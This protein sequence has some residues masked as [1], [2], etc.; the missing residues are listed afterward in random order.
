MQTD[1]SDDMLP[2]A[3]AAGAAILLIGGGLFA[4][5]RR[6]DDEEVHVADTVIAAP[7]EPVPVAPLPVQA[8][9]P[10]APTSHPV[11]TPAMPPMADRPVA[12]TS[13]PT[14]A[15]PAGFDL[16]RFGRHTQ[17]AYAGP[18]AD[19]PFLSLKR[20]LKRA[21]F[22]DGRERM[23]EQGVQPV[24]KAATAPVRPAP[25][26]R[27]AEHITTRIKAPPRPGFRPAWQS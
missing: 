8:A 19:N 1:A 7:A 24:T 25:A 15:I 11:T 18:T 26:P 20:R 6:R 3:G 17:A 27:Q 5:R 9:M 2:I 21:S 12:A 13:G 14:T 4:M 10:A 22:L 16:S 23:A